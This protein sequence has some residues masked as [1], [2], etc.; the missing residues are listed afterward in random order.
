[1][2]YGTDLKAN[3][4]LQ[5]FSEAGDGNY[6]FIDNEKEAQNVILTELENS[7]L[8]SIK[9]ISF[10]VKFNSSV[11]KGYRLIGFENSDKEDSANINASRIS[12]TINAGNSITA[13]YEIVLY[14]SKIEIPTSDLKYHEAVDTTDPDDWVTINVNYTKTFSETKKS[15]SY[16]VGEKN[17]TEKSSENMKFL[18]CVAEFGMLL[19]NSEYSGTS[20][21]ED[22]SKTLSALKSVQKDTYK[23]EF[24]GL[25]SKMV[26][27]ENSNKNAGE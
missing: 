6:S 26:I 10:E 11:I 16:S 3:N 20:T 17:Y 13:I 2:G 21:Y 19:K 1:M 8:S 14:D 7:V 27:S 9:N 24:A 22:I 18:A 12:Q 5:C 4:T 23:K 25:V 15:V